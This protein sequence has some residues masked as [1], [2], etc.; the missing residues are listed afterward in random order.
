M[1]ER[2][3][4]DGSAAAPDRHSRTNDSPAS[5]QPTRP[6]EADETRRAGRDRDAPAMNVRSIALTIMS[7]LAVI[8]VLQ[9]AQRS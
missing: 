2:A 9:Y 8:L 7:V 3:P 5:K 6:R 4:N 1:T